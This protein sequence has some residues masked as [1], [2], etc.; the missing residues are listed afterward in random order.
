MKKR[1]PLAVVLLT[2]VT[3]GI[4]GI[5]WEVS[6]KIEMNARGTK[7]PTAWLL[8]VPLVNIWWLWKY[9]EGVEQT[10]NG[11]MPA[12]LVF[13]LMFFTGVI[14]IAILQHYFNSVEGG[15]VIASASGTPTNDTAPA[16]SEPIT[17]VSPETPSSAPV[18][19]APSPEAAAPTDNTPAAAPP[20]E[21]SQP[22]V[23]P[24][25]TVQG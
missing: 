17:P 13:L 20:S 23:P 15:P 16:A 2:L 7:I 19:P 1:S 12:V 9:S 18:T 8:I 6:T 24:A 14:G 11:Q 5:Y 22:P 4:Y 10:I 21:N 25:P 3:L